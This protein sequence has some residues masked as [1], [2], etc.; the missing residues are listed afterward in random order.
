MDT[1]TFIKGNTIYNTKTTW[2]LIPIGG[3]RP[4]ILR[5]KL[6]TNTVE[7][8][9]PLGN[10]KKVEELKVFFNESANISS[11]FS[12]DPDYTYDG[13][14]RLVSCVRQSNGYK[15][16]LTY[17]L[18]EFK[19]E[20]KTINSDWKWDEMNFDTGVIATDLFKNKFVNSTEVFQS[21][22]LTQR[23]IKGSIGDS[24]VRPIFHNKSESDMTFKVNGVELVVPAGNEMYSIDIML[25][26]NTENISILAKGNGYYDI[27]FRKGVR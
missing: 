21:I 26:P 15:I 3:V 22:G 25:D 27:S 4:P 5:G 1:I 12:T 11:E 14:W 20:K 17:F 24:P 9:M 8:I 13:K 16:G 6:R 2:G 10:D 19:M 18:S 23:Q 7:F